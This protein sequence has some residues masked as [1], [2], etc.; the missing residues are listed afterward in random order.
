MTWGSDQGQALYRFWGA[1]G[2]LL[3]VGISA[4]PPTTDSRQLTYDN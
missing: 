2:A 3:Y 1:G 4:Q